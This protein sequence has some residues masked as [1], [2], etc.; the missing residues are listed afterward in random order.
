MASRDRPPR[1]ED[2]GWLRG[3]EMDYD[4]MLAHYQVQ[5]PEEPH[6]EPKERKT[7]ISSLISDVKSEGKFS[8]KK[9]SRPAHAREALPEEGR[10]AARDISLL[11]Q[12][13]HYKLAFASVEWLE[14]LLDGDE[15]ADGAA[16]EESPEPPPSR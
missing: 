5:E 2:N 12:Q 13:P 8:K 16:E 4:Q 7:F 11:N 3:G 6:E 9:G 10:E 14:G 15:D 1:Q